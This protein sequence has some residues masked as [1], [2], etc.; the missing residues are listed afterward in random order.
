MAPYAMSTAAY[1]LQRQQYPQQA[2]PSACGVERRVTVAVP[3]AAVSRY[4][5]SIISR[6]RSLE[7]LLC[8]PKGDRCLCLSRDGSPHRLPL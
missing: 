7:W 8:S 4:T 3:G 1:I 5:A 6:G 2:A